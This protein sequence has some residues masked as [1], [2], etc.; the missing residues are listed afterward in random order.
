MKPVKDKSIYEKRVIAA[1][2]IVYAFI[3]VVMIFIW[4]VT[5]AVYPPW[6]SWPIII[7]GALMCA[8]L[9]ILRFTLFKKSDK[10]AG[11]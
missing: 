5:G 2:V 9:S 11:R 1:T 6:F 4:L 7:L 3:V 8:V 10:E